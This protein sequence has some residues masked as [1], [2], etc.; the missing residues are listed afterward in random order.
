MSARSRFIIIV[1]VDA[2]MG[3]VASSSIHLLHFVPHMALIGPMYRIAQEFIPVVVKP[4]KHFD[5]QII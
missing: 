5:F 3:G 4:L 1:C 2:D